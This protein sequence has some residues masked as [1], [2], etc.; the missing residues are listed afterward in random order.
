MNPYIKLPRVPMLRSRQDFVVEKCSGKRVLHLGCVNLGLLEEQFVK[1]LL[2]HQKI[3]HSAVELWGVDIDGE[4]IN[5]LRE[6]GFEHLFT[7]DVSAL[8]EIAGLQGE[9]FDIIVATEV[10]EHLQNP[11]LFLNSIKSFMAPG[12]TEF[13][14]SVPNAF[15]LETLIWLLRGVEY[16]HP[17]HN[18][19]FSYLTLTNLLHKNNFD[20]SELY[21]YA[22]LTGKGICLVP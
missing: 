10:M 12:K 21:V 1:Q 4:G 20:I 13:L 9:T 15:R 6:R 3:A 7:G 5:F 11:G 8:E 17:D 14:L 18:Y 16:V 19:W 2:T 22:S